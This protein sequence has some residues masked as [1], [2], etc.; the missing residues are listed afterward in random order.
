IRFVN[1]NQYKK[2]RTPFYYEV[3]VDDE[4]GQLLKLNK[5]VIA[6]ESKEDVLSTQGKKYFNLVFSYYYYD[7]ATKTI[8]KIKPDGSNINSILNLT[9]EKANDLGVSSFDCSKEGD[10]IGLIKLYFKK[11]K[12]F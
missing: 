5:K 3:L 6:T 7:K 8:T 10:I 9:P 12:A 2:E 1:A 11:A 4:K